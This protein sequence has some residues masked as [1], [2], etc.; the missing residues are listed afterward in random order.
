MS[1][2]F[3]EVLQNTPKVYSEFSGRA[4]INKDRQTL[5]TTENYTGAKITVVF[6]LSLSGHNDRCQ[7]LHTVLHGLVL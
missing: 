2:V 5:F 3:E 6:L 7:Y 1:S 4:D